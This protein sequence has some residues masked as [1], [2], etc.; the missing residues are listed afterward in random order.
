[1]KIIKK[2]KDKAEGIYTIRQPVIAFSG[3]SVTQ[4][5]FDLYLKDGEVIE[6]FFDSLE[7]Y[8]EKVKKIFSLLFP[9]ANITIVN[10][11]LSGCRA[12]TGSERLKSD[13]LS[14]NPD[15]TVVCYGLNDANQKQEGLETYK[16]SLKK[17][18]RDLKDAGSEVIFMTPNMCTSRIDYSTKEKG[19][20]AAAERVSQTVNEGWLDKYIEIAIQVCKEE[21]IPVC[22]CYGMWK[23]MYS[24]GVDITSLLSNKVNHPTK[25]MHWMFAYELV[26]TMFEN[27]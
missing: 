23:T 26:K 25:E 5:C 20:Q 13:I 6:T 12:E 9:S 18:F 11:G 7:S 19:V 21:K 8:A 10:A 17:I 14:C 1:M 24:G 4:G 16:E 27:E 2:I 15:L 22:D 3:D